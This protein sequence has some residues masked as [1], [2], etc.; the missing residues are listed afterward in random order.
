MRKW[1]IFFV[2]LCIGVAAV[3]CIRCRS[4]DADIEVLGK[5]DF[6]IDGRNVDFETFSRFV[7]KVNGL[8]TVQTNHVFEV[9]APRSLELSSLKKIITLV[10]SKG[11]SGIRVNVGQFDIEV[12]TE[13]AVHLVGGECYC[14]NLKGS[15]LY[16]FPKCFSTTTDDTAAPYESEV[17]I[18]PDCVEKLTGNKASNPLVFMIGFEPT[19]R[20]SDI[21]PLFSFK[22]RG[23]RI[24]YVLCPQ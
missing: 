8:R 9:R 17:E 3:C 7:P 10:E 15:S 12:I 22:G 6:R 5:D 24:V 21:E 16:Y 4:H 19:S 14:M 11:Y 2:A 23:R 20:L 1:S 18:G 13:M